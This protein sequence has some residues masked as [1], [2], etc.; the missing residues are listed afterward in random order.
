MWADEKGDGFL[1]QRVLSNRGKVK[2]AIVADFLENLKLAGIFMKD[3]EAFGAEDLLGEGIQERLES[4]FFNQ[5]RKWNFT[6]REVMLRM[7]M[8]VL[9]FVAVGIRFVAAG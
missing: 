3:D 1:D 9:C 8:V 6:G 7:V 4:P 2:P 5:C